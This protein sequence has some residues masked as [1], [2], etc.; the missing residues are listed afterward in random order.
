MLTQ[1]LQKE[2]DVLSL[3]QRCHHVPEHGPEGWVVS[4]EKV[5]PLISWVVDEQMKKLQLVIKQPSFYPRSVLSSHFALMSDA[6][7][8]KMNFCSMKNLN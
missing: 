8:L 1:R 6:A 7:I 2:G 5:N 4:A 3:V